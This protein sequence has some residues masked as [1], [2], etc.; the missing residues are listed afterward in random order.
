MS[1]WMNEWIDERINEWMNELTNEWEQKLEGMKGNGNHRFLT[2]LMFMI[3]KD[4]P[5]LRM[6][7]TSHRWVKTHI[8]NDYHFE[9]EGSILCSRDSLGISHNPC[10]AHPGVPTNGP[11]N[12]CERML[13]QLK[14]EEE[15]DEEEEEEGEKK[16]KKIKREGNIEGWS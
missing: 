11:K 16:R 12:Q 3:W 1:E 9:I 8:K 14:K 10:L 5:T 7:M 2:V 15:E 13:S 4:H 6:I